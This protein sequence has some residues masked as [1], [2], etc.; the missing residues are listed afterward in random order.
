MIN[1][2]ISNKLY[3][4]GIVM[5]IQRIG[6]TERWSDAVIFNNVVYMVEVPS[7][8]DAGLSAQSKELLS[9]IEKSLIKYGSNKGRILS[10]TIFLK[11]ITQIAEFNA[12]WDKWL[13]E[14]S[15]PS[16]ACVQANLADAK[17][18]VEIQL[19]AAIVNDDK[20]KVSFL[21]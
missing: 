1:D 7:K 16:R 15:A 13:P 3:F 2:K 14:G 11:D 9:L 21:T 8:L 19:T 20:V 17:Y 18:L 10:A 6:T 5:D 4:V 12:V